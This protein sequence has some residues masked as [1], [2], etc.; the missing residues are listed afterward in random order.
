VVSR[1]GT[2]R[3][4][5]ALWQLLVALALLHATPAHALSEETLARLLIRKGIIT[6]QEYEA[7][8]REVETAAVEA[9]TAAPAEAVDALRDEV[10]QEL[11]R[12][13]EESIGVLLRVEGEGRWQAHRDPGNRRSE[14]TSDLFLR[15]AS[16]GFDARPLPFV[17]ARLLLTSEW[18]GAQATDQGQP[19]DEHLTIDEG[20]VTLRA[21]DSPVYGIFGFRT[22]PFGVFFPRVVTDP[23]TQDAYEV[24]Q[25]GATMGLKLRMWD[26]D[27]S[28]T[29]Y[30]GEQQM[31]HFFDARLF[32]SMAVVRSTGAGLRS[33]NGDV[34]SFILGASVA[35]HKNLVLGGAFLSEPGDGQRNQTATAWIGYT[36]GRFVAEVEFA[37]ALSRERYV[38]QRSGER[39]G[40]SF[41]EK[42]ASVGLTYRP[43][44]AVEIAARLDRFWDDGLAR[45]AGI[46]STANRL[47][48]GAGY[49]LYERDEIRVNLL[50]EYRFTTYRSGGPAHGT[51]VPEQNEAF[52]KVVVS[53]R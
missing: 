45:A 30:R 40:R 27:L 29:A 6:E 49:T 46:W 16:V 22:Q 33:E 24:K 44:R 37:S 2:R 5:S 10:R 31:D 48:V 43:V 4:V 50:G 39:L 26:V 51:A 47:S 25:V 42:V 28:A 36:F 52:A 20:T 12:R 15:R 3:I 23:M 53:Y 11:R 8:R 32:D 21:E 41:T 18:F 19:V 17:T 13:E 7:L 35:P 1:P 34:T 38:L 14:S 9:P